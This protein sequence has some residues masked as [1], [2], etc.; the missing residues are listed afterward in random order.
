[1]ANND[2]NVDTEHYKD[3]KTKLGYQFTVPDDYEL[4]EEDGYLFGIIELPGTLFDL[5]LIHISEPTR[6][7]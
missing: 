4:S 6:P 1:M 7:Y 2:N 3:I 5:S